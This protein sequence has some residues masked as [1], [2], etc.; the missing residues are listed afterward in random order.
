MQT[1]IRL[2]GIDSPE[3]EQA[4]YR[5]SK[6]ALAGMIAGE[7]VGVAVVERDQ[8]GRTVGTIYLD[9]KDINRAMVQRGYAWWYRRHA[10]YERPLQEAEKYAQ[11]QK[12]GLWADPDPVPPWE[13]RRGQ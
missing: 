5:K 9:G 13:W 12:L 4:Y 11:S 2:Y 6:D 1:K 10:K 8:Y 7:T 3:R